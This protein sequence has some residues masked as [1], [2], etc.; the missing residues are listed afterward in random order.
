LP[1][2]VREELSKAGIAA[3]LWKD[4]LALARDSLCYRNGRYYYTA[5]VSGPARAEPSQPV[6]VQAAVRQLLEQYQANS[7]PV[8]RRGQGRTD[9][10]QPVKVLTEDN[11]EVTLLS[12]DLSTTGLRLFGTRRLVGQKVRVLFPTPDGGSRAFQVRILWTCPVGEDLVENGGSFLSED[13]T[14][15]HGNEP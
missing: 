6:S 13:G 8:E 5:P 2:E 11:R 10:V 1:R 14:Q 12:R 15:V 9:I 4:V 3:S 7:N